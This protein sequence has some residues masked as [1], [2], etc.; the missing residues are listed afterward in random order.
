MSKNI[1]V[2][3]QDWG[4]WFNKDYSKFEFW[5][6]K[7]DQAYDKNNNYYF[8][9]LGTLDKKFKPEENITVQIIKSSPIRQFFDFI[10]YRS[11]IKILL[12]KHHFDLIYV[13]FL[14]L[15]ALLP[16]H[17]QKSIGFLR[18]ITPEMIKAKGGIRFLVGYL[19]YALDFI[20]MKKLDLILHNGKS[21]ENYAKKFKT[22][23]K[24]VYNP[25]KISD[26]SF[27]KT[28]KISTIINKIKSK[29]KNSKIIFS[30]ARLVKGKNI[31]LGIKAL[32]KLPENYIYIVAG[33]GE[34]KEN[35]ISLAKK[36]NVSKRFIL[37]DFIEHKHLWSYY[38]GSD[39]F[40]MLSKTNFDGTPNVL[41]EAMYSKL[42]CI[43]SKVP[44]M[45]NIID[46]KTGITLKSWDSEELA[47]KT[48]NIIE[49]K[50]L[51]KSL[52]TNAYNKVKFITKKNKSLVYFFKNEI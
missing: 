28:S 30:V 31:D 25:R 22:K 49:N 34:E 33:E 3:F 10:K 18:D 19:F 27:F 39:L 1:L 32:T 29:N 26:E 17:S 23:A 51:Y 48:L 7:M 52:Q 24:L 11:Q 47:K 13:P 44:A 35:L 41:Q 9:V 46:K 2:L 8:L 16:R 38:K 42:P 36:L 6:K 5:F 15:A 43:V 50:K 40:W 21:L 4:D 45:Q 14:Y 20:A 37:I 12:K